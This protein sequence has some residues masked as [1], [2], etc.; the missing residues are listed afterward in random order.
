MSGQPHM[1]QQVNLYQPILGVEKRLFSAF[2]I[3]VGLG[4]LVV[5]L[6]ALVAFG[7]WR[8]HR[9]ERAL[10][11]LE[12]QEADALALSAR[13]SAAGQPG[14]SIAELD[15]QARNLSAEIAARERALDIVRRGAGAPATGFAARLEA[16]AHRQLDGV[17]LSDI[18]LGSGD[19]RLA[20][21]GGTSDARLVPAFLAALAGEQA[22]AG[23]R[24]DRITLRQAPPAE[25]PARIMF[26]LGAPGLKFSAHGVAR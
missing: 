7:A 8:T 24:F 17:W 10:A 9:T 20:M 15:A 2:T 3:G 11:R 4:V 25:A 1:E 16:L 12:R 22:L 5:C 13:A 6:G 18:V 14:Q 19:G 26:E 23:V 21:R